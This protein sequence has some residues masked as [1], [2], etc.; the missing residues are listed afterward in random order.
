MEEVGEVWV[1][2]LYGKDPASVDVWSMQAQL[3]V[4]VEVGSLQ[5]LD[6]GGFGRCR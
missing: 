1:E 4:S 5:T 3:L 6:P 2:L